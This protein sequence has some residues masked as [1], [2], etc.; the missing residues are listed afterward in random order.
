[1]KTTPQYQRPPVGSH[2]PNRVNGLWKKIR[3]L[4]DIDD[5]EV[6]DA[7]N[8]RGIPISRSRVAAWSRREDS[9]KFSPLNIAELE[10]VLDALI[11]TDRA[12]RSE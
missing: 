6:A 1:M 3:A 9:D 7:L 2:D 4:C 12:D 8:A 5:R 11:E 10:A